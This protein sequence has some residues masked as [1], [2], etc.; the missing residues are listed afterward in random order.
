MKAQ[1]LIDTEFDLHRVMS[2]FHGAFAAGVACQQGTLILPFPILGLD[3]AP[4]V[5]TR[6]LELAMSLRDF[7]L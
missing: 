3:Y 2:A 7:S 5:E 6:F 4:I 1:I